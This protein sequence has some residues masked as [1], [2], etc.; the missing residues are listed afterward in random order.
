MRGFISG[1]SIDFSVFKPNN[2]G[3]SILTVLGI[4]GHF[5]FPKTLAALNV[6]NPTLLVFLLPP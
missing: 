1:L 6:V 2:N 4:D 5:L 3:L